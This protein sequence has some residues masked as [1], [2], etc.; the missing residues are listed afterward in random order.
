[1]LR[2]CQLG[3]RRVAGGDLKQDFLRGKMTC[4]SVL[5]SVS[6]VCVRPRM[7]CDGAIRSSAWSGKE[8]DAT[9]ASCSQ[10]PV[11]RKDIQDKITRLGKVAV[12]LSMSG[13]C[14][15]DEGVER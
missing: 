1:M 5:F 9:I 3:R 2:L 14:R 8:S 11:W 10:S 6:R 13:N 7:F 15:R 12:N 4:V